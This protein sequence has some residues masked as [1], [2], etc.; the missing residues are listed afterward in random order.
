MD[1]D[2]WLQRWQQGR[3]G[4]HQDRVETLL[5]A[6]WDSL[7][8]APGSRVLA[9]LC[10]KSHDL[11]WLAA[12]GMQVVGI[13]LA[14]LAAEQ[15]F[16][17]RKLHATQETVSYGTWWRHGAISI[18]CA[19]IFQV[20][21][22]IIA[23]CDACYDRAALVALPESMR[24]AYAQAVYGPLPAGSPSLLITVDYPQHERAGPPFA[25]SDQEVHTLFDASWMQVKQLEN[26]DI[27]SHEPKFREQ[28]VTRFET[29]VYALTRLPQA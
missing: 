6:H 10:G 8:V 16:A 22:D 20:P 5:A 4:F 21:A 19:D 15:F 17:E 26:R 11:D 18:L 28:G 25:V 24:A 7:G 29:S 27:L 3:T 13:E 12:Q 2:F 1:A 23:A 14:P 9:P